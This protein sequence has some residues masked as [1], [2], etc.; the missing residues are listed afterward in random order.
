MRVNA[1]AAGQQTNQKLPSAFYANTFSVPELHDQC[2]F[3][4]GDA[5]VR[6]RITKMDGR[7]CHYMLISMRGHIA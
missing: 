2:N 3:V 7:L 1:L 6:P 5:V 4:P